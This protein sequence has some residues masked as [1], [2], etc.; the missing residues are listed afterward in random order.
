[1]RDPSGEGWGCGFVWVWIWVWKGECSCYIACVC[2]KVKN[3]RKVAVDV[4]LQFS[5]I[6]LIDPG[7]VILII[8]LRGVWPLHLLNS[9]PVY[10]FLHLKLHVLS[11]GTWCDG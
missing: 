8:S 7:A 3:I 11:G 9:L 4:L 10:S 2:T 1:M 5:A 6:Y